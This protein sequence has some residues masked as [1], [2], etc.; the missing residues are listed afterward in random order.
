MSLLPASSIGDES[1]GFYNGVATQ[2]ARFDANHYMTQSAPSS[3]GDRRQF[4]FSWWAKKAVATEYA[5]L[6]SNLLSG[7]NSN[8][9]FF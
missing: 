7:S 2:S 8:S 9:T 6:Y 4:T 1:T 3:A 5:T